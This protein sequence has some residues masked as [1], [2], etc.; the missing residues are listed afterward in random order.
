LT[1]VLFPFKTLAFLV[2]MILLPVVSRLTAG[3]DPPRALR[4]LESVAKE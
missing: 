2:G 1:V 3:W 4:K